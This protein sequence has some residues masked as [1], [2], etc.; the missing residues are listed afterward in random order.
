MI[1][2]PAARLP[3]GSPLALEPVGPERAPGLAVAEGEG[4]GLEAVEAQERHRPAAVGAQR[5]ARRAARPPAVPSR[6]PGPRPRRRSGPSGCGSGRGASS[7]R[8]S[9][10]RRSSPCG[11]RSLPAG[12]SPPRSDRSSPNRSPPA[13]GHRGRGDGPRRPPRPTVA[14]AGGVAADAAPAQPGQ[15]RIAGPALRR[16]LAAPQGQHRRRRP[17]AIVTLARRRYIVRRAT[18]ASRWT[19]SQSIRQPSSRPCT[20]RS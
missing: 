6:T 10:G 8:W 16:G 20:K 18:S 9:P 5:L 1:T 19:A 11:S 12:R 2:A 13:P 17:A 15:P 14:P 3:P 7:A 4:A